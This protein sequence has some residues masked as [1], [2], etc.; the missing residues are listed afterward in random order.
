MLTPS[1]LDSFSRYFWPISIARSRSL[2]LMMWLDFVAGPG[3]LDDGEPVFAG[4]V[5]CLRH[6]VDNIAIAEDIAERHDAPVNLGAHACIANLRVNRVGEI[7]GTGAGGQRI[8]RPLGV[9]Q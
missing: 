5:A 2:S 7:D 6:D 8:T 3:G 9:K 4:R 1:R